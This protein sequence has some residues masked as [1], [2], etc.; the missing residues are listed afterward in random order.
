[1]ALEIFNDDSK[2][3][4]EVENRFNEL[5]KDI[6]IHVINVDKNNIVNNFMKFIETKH[7]RYTKNTLKIE[8]DHYFNDYYAY[9]SNKT[10]YEGIFINGLSSN[11]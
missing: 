11:Y 7:K 2:L 8:L 9:K 4:I 3:L 5:W 6:K 10:F 1:M